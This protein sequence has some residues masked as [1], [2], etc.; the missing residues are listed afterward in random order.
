MTNLY[1]GFVHKQ[2]ID[3]AFKDGKYF[4]SITPDAYS[5]F[6]TAIFVDEYAYSHRP[7]VIAGASVKSN[8]ASNLHVIG[9][10]KEATKFQV[11]NDIEL[12][13]G[14]VNCPSFEVILAEAF[15]KLAQ[16]FPEQ[17]AP[18][19]I[20]YEQMLNDAIANANTRT[21]ESVKAA[22]AVM[23]KNFGIELTT[24]IHRVSKLRRVRLSDI[25]RAFRILFEGSRVVEISRS[26]EIGV[27]NVD[28]AALVAYALRHLNIGSSLYVSSRNL[29][30]KMVKQ[31]AKNWLRYKNI[32]NNTQM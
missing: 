27:K 9:D 18:Y 5:A 12:S 6:A 20:N 28:D 13:E 4:R 7:F 25:V 14:F 16:V 24:P 19:H 2:I 11:E 17:C 29:L 15:A 21:K 26:A 23:A 1:C 30:A 3:K 31:V 22:V 8:G 10:G 32:D